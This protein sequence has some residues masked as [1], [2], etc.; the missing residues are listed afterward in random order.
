[1]SR[2]GALKRQL[3]VGSRR[4]SLA[5]ES[6]LHSVPGRLNSDA[7][8]LHRGRR[9]NRDTHGRWADTVTATAGAANK[10]QDVFHQLA[11]NCL[12]DVSIVWRQVWL[13]VGVASAAGLAWAPSGRL[14]QAGAAGAAGGVCRGVLP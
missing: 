8:A 10:R 14:G 1:M 4:T 5:L 12:L 3:G 13:I 11:T 9:S 2:D 6:N 7:D